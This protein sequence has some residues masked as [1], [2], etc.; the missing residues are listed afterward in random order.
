M[1]FRILNPSDYESFRAKI[2]LIAYSSQFASFARLAYASTQSFVGI[3]EGQQLK[4]FFPIFSRSG[5]QSIVEVPLFIYTEIYFVDPHFHIDGNIFGRELQRFLNCDVLRLNVYPF[6]FPN[7]FSTDGY[8]KLFTAM[9]VSLRDIH[10]IDE[11]LQKIISKNARSKIYKGQHS[12]L[13]IHAL[14]AS[15]L[16]EFYA[17]YERHIRHLRSTPHSLEYFRHIMNSYSLG[18]DL[19]MFGVRREG[20]LIAAN[21]L[22]QQGDYVEVKFLADDIEERKVFPNNFLYSEMM[23]WAIARGVKYVD[24]GGIPNSMRSNIEFKKSFGAREYPIYTKYVYRNIL[25]HILFRGR[26]KLEVLQKYPRLFLKKL[27]S[28]S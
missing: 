18:Q 11:Y 21:L 10:S 16:Q 22:V 19:M 20:K 26:R 5:S 6:Q 12:G 23:R 17:L 3:Y 13:S 1:D 25:Q 2:H 14:D 8:E 7:N 24:F 4:A 28:K 9:I 27:I 15:H